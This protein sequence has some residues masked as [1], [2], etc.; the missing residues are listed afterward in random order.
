MWLRHLPQSLADVL[1]SRRWPLGNRRLGLALS[2]SSADRQWSE[3][4]LA[5]ARVFFAAA[6]LI[7]VGLDPT[8][9]SRYWEATYALFALYLVFATMVWLAVGRD[10]FIPGKRTRIGT[11][12]A[13]LAW[14]TVLTTITQGPNS[15]FFL[16]FLFVLLSAAYR[17]GFAETVWT[18]VASVSLLGTGA[19]AMEVAPESTPLLLGEL[20]LNR[21][22]M[23]S[24]SL[25]IGSVLL[26]YLAD[27]EKLRRGA[28]GLGTRLV[29][30]I[31]ADARAWDT[32]ESV[33]AEILELFSGQS[34]LLLFREEQTGR[35][36]LWNAHRVSAGMLRISASAIGPEET[37]RHGIE[38]PG[39][40]WYMDRMRVTVALDQQGRRIRPRRLLVPHGWMSQ[41]PAASILGVTVTFA[42]I[43]SGHLLVFDPAPSGVIALRFLQR[44]ASQVAPAMYSVYLLRRLQSRV[45]ALERDRIA[46]ELHDGVVPSLIALQKQLDALRIRTAESA[47]V[48]EELGRIQ[49]LLA[50][51]V[52]GLRDLMHDIEPQEFGPERLLEHLHALVSRFERE[53]GIS[54]RFIADIE[55]VTLAPAVCHELAR[56]T[57][58]ALV[59]ARKYSGASHVLVHFTSRGG[60]PQLIIDY[61]GRAFDFVGRLSHD[62]LD[63]TRR[64]PVLIKQRVRAIGGEL[65]IDSSPTWGV[66]LEI[67]LPPRTVLRKLSA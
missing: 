11:F 34:I 47:S 12:A 9:A 58:D 63:R 49:E 45:G 25:L 40:A 42:D 36:F 28:T 50:R 62:D 26:G 60:A 8:E 21:L 4:V 57:Q 23:R 24:A 59:N 2:Q 7:A 54:A 46:R 19:I 33:A 55:D 18:G 52:L 15:P 22:M 38:V 14:A 37:A 41:H 3:R 32:F 44:L 20:D 5:A 65:A 61:D 66:R 39:D 13:D 6:A 35:A 56:I 17:W 29:S 16:F 48:A 53:T 27:A 1:E 43:G 30:K 64:G 51:E 67:T 10:T 31:R